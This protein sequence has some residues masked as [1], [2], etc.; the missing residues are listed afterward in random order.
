MSV[1]PPIVFIVSGPSGC[2]KS[3]LVQRLLQA[4]RGLLFS[5]SY[6]TRAPRGLERPGEHYHF[7]SR[8]DFEQMIRAGQFLEW[9]EVFGNYYGTHRRYLEQAAAEGKDLVLDI[10]VQGAQQLKCKVPEA[11]SIFVLAP[12]RAELER[13]LRNRSEDAADA[14]ARRLREASREVA[15][16]AAYDYLLVNQDIREATEN[17]AAIVKAERLRRSRMAAL[18]Q[19]IL[20][21]FG[22]ERE[23]QGTAGCRQEGEDLNG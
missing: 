3:S 6:T 13:R 9:A 12:S 18:V 22:V 1:R 14:I 15:R 20:A 16:Y 10:D 2:G 21:E 5:V 17:L 11:V 8:E 23:G 4:D 19:P 7:V